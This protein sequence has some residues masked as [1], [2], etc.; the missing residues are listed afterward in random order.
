ML[1]KK[2]PFAD[3]SEILLQISLLVLL[4]VGSVRGQ[5]GEVS[6]D[7]ATSC[8]NI[9]Q[10]KMSSTSALRYSLKLA[11][12]ELME[13]H[14]SLNET[15]DMQKAAHA[16]QKAAQNMLNDSKRKEK[17]VEEAIVSKHE[18]VEELESFIQNLTI[19][20]EEL[21]TICYDGVLAIDCCQVRNRLNTLHL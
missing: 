10:S 13:L 21:H 19:E 6:Q 17:D 16:M 4:I 18:Y 11:N 14:V 3:C 7:A 12:N 5:G 9:F 20:V 15:Y 1:E 8:H 2:N